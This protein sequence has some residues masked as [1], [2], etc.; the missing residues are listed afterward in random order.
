VTG[1][2]PPEPRPN[3]WNADM[4][5]REAMDVLNWKWACACVGP[6]MPSPRGTSCFCRLAIEQALAL[7][8]AAHIAVK[9]IQE[10]GQ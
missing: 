7:Q 3:R 1:W 2:T 8:R 4:T 10:R 9:L 6:P 5:L